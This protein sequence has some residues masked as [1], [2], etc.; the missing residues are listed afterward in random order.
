MIRRFV[1]G[2]LRGWADR[3]DPPTQITVRISV[4]ELSA[5]TASEEIAALDLQDFAAGGFVPPPSMPCPTCEAA[6][7]RNR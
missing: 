7:E 3:L 4:P 5:P 1:A 6:K 2:L